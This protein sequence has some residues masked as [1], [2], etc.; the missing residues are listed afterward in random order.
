MTNGFEVNNFTEA[1]CLLLTA[2]K[3]TGEV[4][5]PYNVT[6]LLTAKE[7]AAA[8]D[9]LIKKHIIKPGRPYQLTR[10]GKRLIN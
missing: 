6:P 9:S 10:K 5:M 2:F 7:V 4:A 3:Q 8:L 1:E